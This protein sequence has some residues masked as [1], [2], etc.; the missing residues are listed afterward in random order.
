MLRRAA[1]TRERRATARRPIRSVAATL[2]AWVAV[3]VTLKP[4]R[5][6]AARLM[7][8]RATTASGR[9]AYRRSAARA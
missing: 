6:S 2:P 3:T 1:S 8:A 4:R 7:L 5:S 9:D